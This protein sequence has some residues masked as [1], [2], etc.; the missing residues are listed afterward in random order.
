[1]DHL[2]YLYS[3]W[4]DKFSTQLPSKHQKSSAYAFPTDDDYSSTTTTLHVVVAEAAAVEQLSR[5]F[6][7]SF[8][9]EAEFPVRILVTI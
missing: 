2:S 8:C 3:F 6:Y 4:E 5:Y 1:M 9:P 7:L